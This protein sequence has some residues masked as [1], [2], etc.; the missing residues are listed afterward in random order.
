MSVDSPLGGE[1]A[2][3]YRDRSVP[4][5]PGAI[6]VDDAEPLG[7]IAAAD[8]LGYYDPIRIRVRDCRRGGVDDRVMTK[9]RV[10][11]LMANPRGFCAGVERA[12]QIVETALDKFG[13]P[14]YV[15]HE[16]VHNRHVVEG[17]EGKGA[18]F[19]DCLDEVPDGARVIFSAHGVSNTVFREAERRHLPFIDATC[20]LVTKVHRE[21]QRHH[22]A[23][24]E[25]VLIGHADHP[26][27]VGTM[28]QLPR[29]AILLVESATQ[30]EGVAPRQPDEL[31]YVTQTTLSVDDTVAIVSILK[32]RFPKILGPRKDDICYATTNRQEAVK[33]IAPRCDVML[34]VGAPNSSNARRLVEV[35]RHA[36]CRQAML[37]EGAADLDWPALEPVRRIGLA[38]GASAPEIKVQEVVAALG[39]RFDAAIEESLGPSET[40]RFSLPRALN[41]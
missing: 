17:L 18:V 40:V 14:V 21:A 26:E 16:I 22:A 36:G 32:R 19:V 23:G 5:T 10:T 41:T 25:V 12:I 9:S 24:R 31:A 30:A 13:A 7:T 20:P 2:D 29:G 28:G 8:E 11:V 6:N 15:R 34:V 3:T 1:F 38:A 33:R 27:V 35:A 39:E 4:A 37:V